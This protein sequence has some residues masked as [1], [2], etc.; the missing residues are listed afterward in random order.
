MNS[1][2][3]ATRSKRLA[4]M[5]SACLITALTLSSAFVVTGSSIATV[6]AASAWAPGIAYKAGDQVTYNGSAYQCLQAHTSQTGWEPPNVP[7]LW[8]LV[9]SGATPTATTKPTATNTPKPTTAGPTATATSTAIPT[10]VGSTATPT[11]T[12]TPKPTATA[13]PGSGGS[14]CA[15]AYNNGIAYTNGQVVSYNGHNWQA[16]WWTQGEAPSTGG[17]GVWTDQGACAIPPT[18]TPLPP[19]PTITPGGPT[20]TPTPASSWPAH[21]F[22]PYTYMW[23]SPPVDMAAL[24]RSNGVKYYTLAFMLSSGCKAAWDGDTLLAQS[25]IDGY[26]TNLRAAGG[27]VI[28]SFGGADGKYLE[29]AC[30]T[31]TDL[32]TQYQAVVDKYNL[33]YIDFD[34]ENDLGNTA[35]STRRSQAIAQVQQH[36]ASLGKSLKVSFT[37]GVLPSGMPS[38]QINV[39]KS[40]ITNGVNVGVVNIMAMDYGQASNQM[41]TDAI[42]AATASFN[43]VKALYPSKTDAQVWAMIGITPMIG[44]NDESDETFTLSD[45]QQVLTFAQ[46]NNLALLSFWALQRDHQ[47]TTST[48][49]AQDY[50][51]SITQADYAFSNIFK[52]V[53][54]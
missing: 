53:T 27:D 29:D 2:I 31:A 35:S 11:A 12:S 44:A 32:A 9:S 1:R 14:N 22:A 54:H 4:I 41:G 26:I 8:Q 33:T 15:T 7:A 16:K 20:P 50:C 37:L 46:Q 40:A 51:S 25:N 17:S 6:Q 34:I 48:G 47:C 24:A 30:T 52:Q 5:L 45:A 43:Q 18:P 3:T 10:T 38:D 13:T 42:S 28:V 49:G 21:V 39:L 19:T 36:Q 23:D